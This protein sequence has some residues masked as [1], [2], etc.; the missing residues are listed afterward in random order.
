MTTVS[1]TS[2][3]SNLAKVG[4]LNLVQQ[5]TFRTPTVT[6]SLVLKHF[7]LISI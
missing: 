7:P 6:S 5:P 3:I 4:L 2:P 1:N